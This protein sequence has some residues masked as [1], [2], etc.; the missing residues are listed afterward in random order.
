[1]RREREERERERESDRTA[2]TSRLGGTSC[3]AGGRTSCVAGDLLIVNIRD[4]DANAT[5]HSAA[6]IAFTL[7]HSKFAFHSF[8]RCAP[9]AHWQPTARRQ[10]SLW[11]ER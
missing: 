3:V 4:A 1:M 7:T 9:V 10:H 11:H 6:L 2:S 8:Q 5:S